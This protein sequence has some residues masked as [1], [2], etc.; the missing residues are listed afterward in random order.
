MRNQQ[1][2]IEQMCKQVVYMD[3]VVCY[4]TLKHEICL[5]TQ[6]LLNCLFVCDDQCT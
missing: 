4:D 1:T 3:S 6:C 2:L 5:L